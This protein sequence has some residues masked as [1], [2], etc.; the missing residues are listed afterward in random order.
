[1]KNEHDIELV[2][3]RVIFSL[4]DWLDD[5]D[6]QYSIARFGLNGAYDHSDYGNHASDALLAIDDA[7]ECCVYPGS[8]WVEI[9]I[10]NGSKKEIDQVKK[11]IS[12]TLDLLKEKLA[13]IKAQKAKELEEE[14]ADI[15]PKFR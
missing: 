12:L 11:Q 13:E 4:P 8:C 7:E 1:M 3:T 2:N 6:F 15:D 9:S 5:D 14:M 10:E